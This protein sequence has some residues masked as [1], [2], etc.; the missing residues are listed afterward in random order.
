L[1]KATAN[2]ILEEAGVKNLSKDKEILKRIK[3]ANVPPYAPP[4]VMKFFDFLRIHI[5]LQSNGMGVG[6]RESRENIA[7]LMERE[8]YDY[9]IYINF[10]TDY[11]NGLLESYYNKKENS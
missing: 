5:T 8:G 10:V 3:K 9:P 11:E 6:L 4:S 2:E 1:L 7:K